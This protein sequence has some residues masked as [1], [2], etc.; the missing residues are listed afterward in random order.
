MWNFS[1]YTGTRRFIF[2]G[3][4]RVMGTS[5]TQA[6]QITKSVLGHHS[7]VMF[8]EKEALNALDEFKKELKSVEE[9]IKQRNGEL[10]VP[11]EYLLPSYIVNSISI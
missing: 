1:I 10:G 3:T 6:A 5:R 2:M 4:F 11:Y 7:E 9:K 8:V